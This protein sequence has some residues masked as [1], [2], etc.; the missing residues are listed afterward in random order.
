MDEVFRIVVYVIVSF[1]SANLSIRNGRLFGIGLSVIFGTF[2]YRVFANLAW[3]MSGPDTAM[4]GNIG[5]SFLIA[6]TM[7]DMGVDY[8]RQRKRV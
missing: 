2:I 5:A 1:H 7:Y 3:G 4:V 8:V 6:T